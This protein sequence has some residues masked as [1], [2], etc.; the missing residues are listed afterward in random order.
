MRMII[1]TLIPMKK[2]IES[3]KQ[4]SCLKC[5]VDDD[6]S[7]VQA[8]AANSGGSASSGRRENG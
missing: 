1:P 5:H 3:S 8:S 6:S 4:N 2:M 7:G